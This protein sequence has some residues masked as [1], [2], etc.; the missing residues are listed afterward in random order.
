MIIDNISPGV[1]GVWSPGTYNLVGILRRWRGHGG[2]YWNVENA[3]TDEVIEWTRTF[4]AA[5][6]FAKHYERWGR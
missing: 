6:K 3:R 5:R 1:W 2:T 4:N